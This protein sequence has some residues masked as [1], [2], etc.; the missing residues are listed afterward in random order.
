MR[1]GDILTIARRSPTLQI[2]QRWGEAEH[3]V[4]SEAWRLSIEPKVR[5]PMAFTGGR[6]CAAV[7]L[8]ADAGRVRVG[9]PPSRKQR[10]ETL[11]GRISSA[12]GQRFA[13]RG[14]QFSVR[15]SGGE[16]LQQERG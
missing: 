3:F 7:A 4:E 9:R 16:R 8:V 11:T 2:H 13:V 10:Y 6:W 5:G 12:L 1:L 14:W 15:L